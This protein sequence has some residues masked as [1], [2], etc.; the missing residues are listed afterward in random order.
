LRAGHE[1]EVF[2]AME[3]AGVQ[4]DV[5]TRAAALSNVHDARRPTYDG[6]G[7]DVTQIHTRYVR[8]QGGTIDIE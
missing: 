6:A 1:S 2:E 8:W 3:A 4:P 7:A 5:D